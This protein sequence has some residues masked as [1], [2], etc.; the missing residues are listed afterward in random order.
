VR[1][2]EDAA[3][4]PH[5]FI[6]P[7]LIDSHTHPLDL[8]LLLLF[9]DLD[10]CRTV[11]EVVERLRA[12][13]GQAVEL[14][15]LLGYRL[16][17][18]SLAEKRYPNRVELDSAVGDVPVLVYRVDGH[19]A[20]ANSSGLALVGDRTLA[21]PGAGSD[22]VLRGPAYEKAASIFKH[23]LKPEHVKESLRLA[24][25]EA[26]RKGVTAIGA[27]GGVQDTSRDEWRALLDGLAG[28]PVRAEPFLQTWDVHTA[29]D[30]GLKRV[31]GC[32][33]IDG[34]FGS[35]TAALLSDYSDVA[36]AGTLYVTDEHL[37]A[38]YKTA[39]AAGLQTAV[40]AIGDRAV[41]QVIR[42]HERAGT[43]PGNP[44]RHRIEHAELLSPVQ[45]ERVARLGLVLGVQPAFEGAWG[46]P[47]RMYA[48]RLGERWRSTN[49][50]RSLLDAGVALAGGSDAPITPT[51][52]VAGIRSAM[53]RPNPGQ[54]VTGPEALAMFTSAAAFS[55]GLEDDMGTIEPGKQADFTVLTADPRTDDDC[56]VVATFR[57]GRCIHQDCRLSDYL[58]MEE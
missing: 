40:H 8:G 53:N 23:H 22:G 26:A 37:V 45:V 54:R 24:G 55:L 41:E 57:S 11:A 21:L 46:G 58:Q 28:L 43:E 52:P 1:A 32:L 30:F 31:G 42:C 9:A 48:R 50:Y 34:S 44:L 15:M 18:D 51:D 20:C 6:L 4:D 39:N 3:G 38:F 2:V 33:L 14:G 36:G 25:I 7:G 19:S 27:L 35:G 12:R 56:A 16:E 5:G 29:L 49:P 47:D 17:P 10:G 13:R